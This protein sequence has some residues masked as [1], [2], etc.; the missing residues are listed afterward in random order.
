[1]YQG[2]YIGDQNARDHAYHQGTAWPWLMGPF[3]S[4]YVKT[5]GNTAQSRADAWEFLKPFTLH[6]TQ[7]G[8]GSISEI[9]DGDSPN[10]PRGCFAQAWSVA[11]I[12]RPLWEDVL[13]QA[14]PWPH[15]AAAGVGKAAASLAGAEK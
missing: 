12:L 11:E 7:V 14:S 15:E 3:V 4:G 8:L 10:T 9:A 13:Q 1:G 5:M 2:R 6:L